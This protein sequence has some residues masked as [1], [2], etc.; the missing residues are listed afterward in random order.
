MTHPLTAFR[1]AHDL[2]LEEFGD[3]VGVGKSTVWRWE[4]GGIPERAAMETIVAI[5]DGRLTPNDF[6][7]VEIVPQDGKPEAA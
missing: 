1:E 5:T 7:G 2:T 6:Y 4:A 3:L